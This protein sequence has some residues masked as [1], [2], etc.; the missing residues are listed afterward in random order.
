MEI[1]QRRSS[2]EN[3][4]IEVLTIDPYLW[5]PELNCSKFTGVFTTPRL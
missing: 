4:I 5:N 2:D 3:F 1:I